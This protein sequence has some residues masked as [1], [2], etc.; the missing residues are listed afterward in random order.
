MVE[1]E[2]AKMNQ[3]LTK[4][5]PAFIHGRHTLQK[6]V[7]NTGWLF[8]NH[9]F[10]AV[11][12]LVVGVWLARYLGPEK[13]GIFNYSIAFTVLFSAFSTLGLDSIVVRNIVTRPELKDEIIGT[14]FLLKLVGGLIALAFA[15]GAALL[16]RP[17]DKLV[18]WM[19]GIIAAGFVFQ[20]FDVIAFW[21]HSQIKIK[22][23]VYVKMAAF[24]VASAGKVALIIMGA[25]LVWFAWV[26]LF[27]IIIGAAGMVMA[28]EAY[29]NR[30]KTLRWAG[31]RARELLKDSWPLIIASLAFCVHARID[32]VMLAEMIGA[33]EV[34]KYSVA[35][36]IIALFEYIPVLVCMSFA[37]TLTEAKTLGEDMYYKRLLNLYRL[38][39]NMFLIITVPIF[40]FSGAIV[41]NLYGADYKDSGRLLA[42]MSL[43]L[44]FVNFATVREIFIVNDG[45]F[46]YSLV[47]TLAAAAV[48]IAA[49]YL[50]IPL[51]SS[52]GAI[53]ASMTSFAVMVFLVDMFYYK[54]FRNLK[55]MARAITTPL[56]LKFE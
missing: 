6:V 8:L 11:V 37:P 35:V 17:E 7:A 38:M 40:L 2:Q 34:G 13:L 12:S 53:V 16:V 28:Y 5:L 21:F 24:L 9:A 55:T 47:T 14:V 49:N 32:H 39:F 42:L 25:S 54:T 4:L 52:V 31:K 26:G 22:P 27:E 15:V 46:G 30:L 36:N 50:L 56:Q 45:L 51:Y 41:D 3:T 23:M 33:G 18:Q 10:R 43:K 1:K 44:F 20:S 19:V 29:G 48:N